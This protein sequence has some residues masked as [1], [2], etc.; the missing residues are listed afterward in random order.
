MRVQKVR[1]IFLHREANFR[2]GLL[3]VDEDFQ[4]SSSDE[5]S[6]TSSSGSDDSDAG[7]AASKSPAK[8]K[9]V[10]KAPETSG[11]PS[12]KKVRLFYIYRW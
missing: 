8:P 5:G 12:P 3:P 9:K 7:S 2:R 6:P 4:A 10:K 1:G 11:S